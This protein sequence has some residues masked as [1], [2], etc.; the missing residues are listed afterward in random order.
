VKTNRPFRTPKGPKKFSVYVRNDKGS[1]VKVNFGDPHMEIKRDDPARRKN[2]RAR[3]RCDSPGPQW[4]PRYWS[5]KMWDTKP[6]SEILSMKTTRINPYPRPL[7]LPRGS[8]RPVRVSKPLGA[9]TIAYRRGKELVAVGGG[10]LQLN[11]AMN[12]CRTPELANRLKLGY[13]DA[14]AA[15]YS[16]P[17][18]RNPPPREFQTYAAWKSAAKRAGATDFG[19]DRDIDE[20]FLVD[21]SQAG[22]RSIGEWDGSVGFINSPPGRATPSSGP[23]KP[24]RRNPPRWNGEYDLIHVPKNGP[25]YLSDASINTKGWIDAKLGSALRV[26]W[27]SG[28][29]PEWDNSPEILE[30]LEQREGREYK[31]EFRDNVYNSQ[32][33]FNQVFTF[34]VYIPADS[35][36]WIYEDG[37]YVALCLHKG[38]DTRGNYTHASLYKP[39][40]VLG[41]SGFTDWVLG[42]DVRDGK[43]NAIASADRYEVGYSNH[44]TSELNRFLE[45]GKDAHGLWDMGAFYFKSKAVGKI[46]ANPDVR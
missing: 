30:Y 26:D 8:Q 32:N 5:C 42:W 12:R 4:K 27:P 23:F 25:G 19:G 2:F 39:R 37:A 24:S 46:I 10:E 44:P 41:E 29:Q 7:R 43:K 22:P 21:I 45:R 35:E 31:L 34:S 11:E 18:R 9:S 16:K 40:D 33:D 28:E 15:R 17:S 3:H 36:D 20:A 13:D 1:V 38:G 14:L 6:V